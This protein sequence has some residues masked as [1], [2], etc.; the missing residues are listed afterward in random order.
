MDNR[1]ERENEMKRQTGRDRK[2]NRKR[3]RVK[4][5]NKWKEKRRKSWSEEKAVG[6]SSAFLFPARQWKVVTH[7]GTMEPGR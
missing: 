2:E 5:I 3:K 4:R 6:V 1:K 7:S